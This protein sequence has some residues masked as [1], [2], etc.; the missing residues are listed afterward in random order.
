MRN[1]G[2]GRNGQAIEIPERSVIVLFAFTLLHL[3]L[4]PSSHNA[5]KANS[6]F[7]RAFSGRCCRS[8]FPR[9][10]FPNNNSPKKVFPKVQINGKGSYIYK[11]G[12]KPK[13]EFSVLSIIE[14]S[15]RLTNIMPRVGSAISV[16][17]EVI[18][19]ILFPIVNEACR[20]L[21]DGVI[22]AS[23]LYVASLLGMSFPSCRFW[24]CKA[25]LEL[26]I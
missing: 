26:D 8:S 5:E 15:R 10:K 25:S 16:T 1:F 21:D 3:L 22:R 18:K 7:L 9:L 14:E 12:R 19:M 11:K 17:D 4:S 13:P 20:V 24:S 23:N 6:I 2:R